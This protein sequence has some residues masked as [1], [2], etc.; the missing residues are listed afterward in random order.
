MKRRGQSFSYWLGGALI[1][2]LAVNVYHVVPGD[3][4]DQASPQRVSQASEASDPQ[5][6]VPA[7]TV[8]REKVFEDAPNDLAEAEKQAYVPRETSTALADAPS[9]PVKRL[10]TLEAKAITRAEIATMNRELR[11]WFI[12]QPAAAA[13]WLNEQPEPGRFDQSVAL[14]AQHLSEQKDYE[15][16]LSWAASIEAR[17]IR[18]LVVT[19]VVA[20]AFQDGAVTAMQV[21]EVVPDLDLRQAIFS[22]DYWD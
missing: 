20:H 7:A 16:A 14:V 5:Q 2:S 13:A 10:E 6:Q 19:D 22:G 8:L 9:A 1:C 17:A 15:N 3:E 4:Y 11:A 18:D 21:Q 12:A